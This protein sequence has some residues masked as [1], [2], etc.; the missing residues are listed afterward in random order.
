M[1][2][3]IRAI[4]DAIAGSWLPKATII[5]FGLS[6]FFVFVVALTQNAY[7]WTDQDPPEGIASIDVWKLGM[8]TGTVGT[9]T[10]FLVTLYVTAV[11]N[12]RLGR[13]YIPSLTMMLR[14][15]RVAASQS[16][17]AIIAA[18]DAKNTG[19]GLC[20]VDRVYWTLKAL[21]P[22]DDETIAEMQRDFAGAPDNE[23]DVEFPWQEVVSAEVPEGI[24]VEPNE[25]EQLTYDF[26]IPA[27]ISAVIV[28]A[29]VPNASE[30][31]HVEGWY[32][33]TVHL[34]RE[35]PN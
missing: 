5:A 25:T 20:R 18:L 26:I 8:V 21:A 12:Y 22:Y 31:K 3:E 35:G 23:Q 4:L 32:R 19:T 34:G 14:I 11:R 2:T 10:A 30:P 13:E 24:V 16:H 29:W 33:R 17:D 28:S 6:V 9:A 27:Q 15:S 7:E 1:G